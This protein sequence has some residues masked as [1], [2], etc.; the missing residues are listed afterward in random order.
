M[1]WPSSTVT[2]AL[3]G[4]VGITIDSSMAKTI[5]KA[6]INWSGR[7]NPPV[8]V[9]ESECPDRASAILSVFSLTY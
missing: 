3:T 4:T 5:P 1:S 8:M 9:F 6:T 7:F 2:S